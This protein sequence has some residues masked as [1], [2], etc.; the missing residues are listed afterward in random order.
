MKAGQSR[1]MG[2][3]NGREKD[4]TEL[5]KARRCVSAGKVTGI[6]A[7]ELD[8]IKENSCVLRSFVM[9]GTGLKPDKTFKITCKVTNKWKS[10]TPINTNT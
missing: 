4:A 10:K 7:L 1:L 8:V 2:E 6:G 5:F 3:Q 9:K